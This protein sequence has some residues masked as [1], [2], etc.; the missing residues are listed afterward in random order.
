[1]SE[2]TKSR[3]VDL[4]DI[5]PEKI[6]VIPGGVGQRFR[7]VEKSPAM[8]KTLGMP[9]EHYFLA[10]GS[11]EPRKNLARLLQAWGSIQASL[12][13]EIWLVLAGA[14]GKATTTHLGRFI[15]G[16]WLLFT[17]PPTKVLACRRSK[18]CPAVRL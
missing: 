9:C 14:K 2:F 13:A 10:L 11:L 18:P 4:W 8:A 15:Q 3:I 1:M 16:R 17:S 12:P 7:P 6:I 5:A